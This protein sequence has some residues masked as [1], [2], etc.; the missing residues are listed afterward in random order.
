MEQPLRIL[1]QIFCLIQGYSTSALL[2]FWVILISLVWGAVQ[3]LLRCWAAS[4]ASIHRTPAA[5]SPAGTT[6]KRLQ[7]LLHVSRG[8][9]RTRTKPSATEECW[10]HQSKARN[11]WTLLP[12]RPC[13][14][15]VLEEKRER[16]FAFLGQRYRWSLR[17]QK[18]TRGWVWR[19]K[20]GTGNLRWENHSGSEQTSCRGL[21]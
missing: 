15:L 12:V 21:N 3:C 14:N 16:G 8:E 1:L 4:P 17:S 19:S 11:N 9:R 5:P 6:K 10:P 2:T 18:I 7:T 20:P 13:I